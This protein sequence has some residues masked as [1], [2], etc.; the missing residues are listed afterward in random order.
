MV[1]C[2]PR[3]VYGLSKAS[4]VEL[5]PS[6]KKTPPKTWKKDTHKYKITTKS[7]Y[8]VLLEMIELRQY[9]QFRSTESILF[10]SKSIILEEHCVP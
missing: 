2:T 10:Q 9:R 8:S 3:L 4:S 5:Y 6:I 7:E 1:S